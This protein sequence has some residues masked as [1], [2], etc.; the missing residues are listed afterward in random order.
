MKKLWKRL[1]M[2]GALIGCMAT[3]AWAGNVEI[4]IENTHIGKGEPEV[5]YTVDGY[6]ITASKGDDGATTEGVYHFDK[7]GKVSWQ[8]TTESGA[9]NPR[10][11]RYM[12]DENGN[13]I[14]SAKSGEGKS[15][16][17]YTDVDTYAYDNQGRVLTH[18]WDS[19]RELLT[20]YKQTDTFTYGE[21]QIT[22]E[23][24]TESSEGYQMLE[25]MEYMLN[26]KTQIVAAK[27][28]RESDEGERFLIREL[29][30]TYDDDGNLT[31]SESNDKEDYTVEFFYDENGRCIKSESRIPG[32][33]WYSACIYEYD[34]NGN[35]VS[36][37]D[38][39]YDADGNEKL[40]VKETYNCEKLSKVQD[41]PVYT[42]VT[43]K[44]VY[45]YDAVN[46]A[47]QTGVAAGIGNDQFAPNGSC[48]RAQL[49]TF[50]WRAA[51]RP[52]PET[53]E[54]PFTDV[55]NPNAYYYKAVLWAVENG[56]TAGVGN[57]CFDP[58]GTCTRAQIVAFIYR[59][60]GDTETYT[61]NPFQDVKTN[62]FYYKAVLWAVNN[63]VV[64]G[65]SDTTFSPNETC[66]RAQGVSFLYRGIGL[67]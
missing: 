15:T 21:S 35:V 10:I 66:T 49:V 52:E 22:I 23:S 13:L 46:W 5:Q 54:S 32:E 43:D 9:E 40:I 6:Y 67:Y 18:V 14:K 20:D 60:S 61:D 24:A 44:T 51:G 31:K 2:L 34:E 38:M 62:A 27:Y 41:D 29:T 33:K 48:T 47:T 4:D 39:E 1:V 28:Y 45:Y 50:L 64:A 59:A 57:N 36:A 30:Y 7:Y 8:E 16:G 53:T 58:E 56:I 37:S 26:D 3:A 55:R 11:T 42:D 12:Y 19:K 17:H 65:T 25:R 63:G